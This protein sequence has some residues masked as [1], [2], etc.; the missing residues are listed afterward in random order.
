MEWQFLLFLKNH[1]LYIHGMEHFIFAF[2]YVA[3]FIIGYLIERELLK[4]DFFDEISLWEIISTIALVIIT[5]AFSNISF[6]LSEEAFNNAFRLNIFKMR[7]IIDFSGIA[8]LYAFQSRVSDYI[9]K[10]EL[11]SINAMLKSQYENYRNYQEIMEQIRIQRHDLKHHIALLR[12]ETD[13]LKRENRLNTLEQE[14]DSTDY[15][16]PTGNSVL[17][18]ML[19]SKQPLMKK[20]KINFTCVADGALLNFMH[21]T[22]I[23]TVIGN[24][25][26]NAIESVIMIEDFE[27]RIIHFSLSKKK[28]FIFLQ[29]RNY[30]ENPPLWNGKSLITTK[31][32]KKNHGYGIKSI[33]Y[34]IEKYGGNITVSI[35][36]NWFELG[37]LIPENV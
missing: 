7:T 23:C 26:D 33:K 10:K 13:I 1:N 4:K 15:I 30:C 34:S 25:L 12:G 36:D 18:V 37:I 8:I 6:L 2:I 28:Q 19:S 29:I 21:V 9:S 20:N 32:D 17:D 24:A 11:A 14:L 16:D 3:V 27:K 31:K 22:D 5:F 35:K